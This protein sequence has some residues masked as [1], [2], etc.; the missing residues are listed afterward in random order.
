MDGIAGKKENSAAV[1]RDR[2]KI[3][4]PMMVVAP[5]PRVPGS[6]RQPPGQKPAPLGVASVAAVHPVEFRPLGW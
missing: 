1:L 6:S 4:P 5:A 3:T 2:P